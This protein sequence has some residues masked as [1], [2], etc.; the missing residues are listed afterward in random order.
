MKLKDYIVKGK[1]YFIAIIVI[2]LLQVL[3]SF[4]ALYPKNIFDPVGIIKII[5]VGYAGYKLRL[6]TKN[7]AVIGL[8]LFSSVIWYIPFVLP[9]MI[10]SAGIINVLLVI[11]TTSIINIILYSAVA[12]IGNI[13][14]SGNGK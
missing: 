3:A 1:N 4:F 13:I 2:T 5:I 7:S 11:A 12:V 10:F 14:S 6:G 8:L 9:G